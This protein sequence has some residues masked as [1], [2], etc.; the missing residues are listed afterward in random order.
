MKQSTF[1]QSFCT[2]V[3]LKENDYIT[4]Q[5]F[6]SNDNLT[7][8]FTKSLLLQ[9]LKFGCTTLDYDDSEISSD[10]I[11]RGVNFIFVSIYKIHTLFLSLGF[12][13]IGFF[14]RKGF[15]I[16]YFIYVMDI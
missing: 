9:T 10:A 11:M 12:F 16:T 14:S 7:D 5:Q 3:I 6:F 13:P 8:L 1:H 15:N 4:V 2:L